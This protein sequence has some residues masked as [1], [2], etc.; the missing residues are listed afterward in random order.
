MKKTADDSY[1]VGIDYSMNSPAICIHKCKSEWNIKN[2]SFHFYSSTKKC[3]IKSG[4]FNGG[5]APLYKKNDDIDRWESNADWAIDILNPI[6]DKI[7]GIS[8]EG[9]SY[10]SKGSLLFNI[11]ENTVILKYKLR[12]LLPTIKLDIF[13]PQQIK[14]N[15]TGKGNSN[16]EQM[17]K[18]FLEETKVD[19]TK[20]INS[21]P[22]GNPISDIVDSYWI[23][24][25]LY[26]N[27]YG[28]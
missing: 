16:K 8:I 25:L 28:Q 18:F 23:C 19:I 2:C 27:M 24:K 22:E 10:G 12:K 4:Q 17:Y 9:Y 5:P 7:K 26:K 21:K 14:K 15:S 1:V 13:A 20:F 11:A 6:K 3:Q